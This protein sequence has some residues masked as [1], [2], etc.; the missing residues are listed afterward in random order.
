[1][2]INPAAV[3]GGGHIHRLSESDEYRVVVI[4]LMLTLKTTEGNYNSAP[5]VK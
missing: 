4:L 2:R 3:L 5:L 1:M